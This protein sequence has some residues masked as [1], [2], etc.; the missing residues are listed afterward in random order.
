MSLEVAETEDRGSK[1]EDR[2]WNK[3]LSFLYPLSSFFPFEHRQRLH[4]WRLREH[5]VATQLGDAVALGEGARIL[6]LGQRIAG[7]IHQP[8]RANPHQLATDVWAQAGARRI[9]H[10]DI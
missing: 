8:A 10:D 9:G 1:I 5:I 7:D 2:G 4:M 3:S 6:D